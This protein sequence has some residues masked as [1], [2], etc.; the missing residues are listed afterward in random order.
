ME[1][2]LLRSKQNKVLTGVCGGFAE[3]F[4]IDPTIVRVVWIAVSLV[5]GAGAIAVSVIAYVVAAIIMPEEKE[6]DDNNMGEGKQQ[7]TKNINNESRNNNDEIREWNESPE[8]NA[9]KTRLFIGSTLIILG[10]MFLAREIF[11][12]FDTKY[13]FPLILIGIG[14]YMIFKKH[15]NL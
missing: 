4:N 12:W 8:F 9:R 13:F 2:K 11:Y 6:T 1:K 10:I 5:F 15:R 14:V 3:Y 7:Q